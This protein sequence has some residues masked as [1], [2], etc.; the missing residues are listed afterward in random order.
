MTKYEGRETPLERLLKEKDE[1]FR[2]YEPYHYDDESGTYE[3]GVYSTLAKAQ[4]RAQMIWVKK[5]YPGEEKTAVEEMTEH[6][7]KVPYYGDWHEILI[8][9]ITVDIDIDKNNCGWT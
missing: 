9:H 8:D 3:Y 1:V 7:I 6:G 4:V 5:K 2:V